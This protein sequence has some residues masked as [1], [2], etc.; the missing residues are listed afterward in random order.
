MASAP[1][2]RMRE[3]VPWCKVEA[4]NNNVHNA[5]HKVSSV[6]F[7]LQCLFAYKSNTTRK[8]T[9][10]SYISLVYIIGTFSVFKNMSILFHFIYTND[11]SYELERWEIILA[12]RV[13]QGEGVHSTYFISTPMFYPVIKSRL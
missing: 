13:D 10:F 8:S 6:I 12:D 5:V 7:F 1:S 9:Q 3:P 11:I 2:P 4:N